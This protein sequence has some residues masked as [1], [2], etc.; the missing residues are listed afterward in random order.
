MS[1]YPTGCISHCNG[2]ADCTEVIHTCTSH[3]APIK[4]SR[5]KFDLPEAG[6]VIHNTPA[7]DADTKYAIAGMAILAASATGVIYLLVQV[8]SRMYPNIF[9]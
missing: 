7:G 4:S 2:G 1:A 6:N 3:V 5:P 8:A 9:N